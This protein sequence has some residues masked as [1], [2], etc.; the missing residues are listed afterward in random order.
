VLTNVWYASYFDNRDFVGT[1]HVRQESSIYNYWGNSPPA[2]LYSADFSV[3]YSG[4][5]TFAQTTSY[6]FDLQV[7]GAARVFVD[8]VQLIIDS[9]YTGKSRR[10]FAT[11]A[12][13]AGDHRVRV[14]YYN[15]HGPA[16]LCLQWQAQVFTGWHGRYY[17]NSNFSG[18]PIMIRD[19]AEINF[20]WGWAQVDGRVIPDGFSVIWERTV[21]LPATGDY[22]F[23]ISADDGFRVIVDGH[24]LGDLDKLRLGPNSGEQ[25]VRLRAGRHKIEVQYVELNGTAGH[26]GH[27][28]W[29]GLHYAVAR[30][31][32]A[33]KIVC[34]GGVLM[35]KR[36][37]STYRR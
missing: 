21:N 9:Y 11:V 34:R 37:T 16:V 24:V 33:T 3:V 5:W 20:P 10:Q 7:D 36:Q 18:S 35:G 14:E 31:Q 2:G 29:V 28:I 1:P 8:D 19:D 4:T 17:N 12:M 6:L 23:T 30:H 13:S 27:F 26:R 32:S 15:A 25:T 22:K